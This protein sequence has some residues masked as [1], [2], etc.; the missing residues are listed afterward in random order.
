MQSLS[1][2]LSLSNKT[3]LVSTSS[4]GQLSSSQGQILIWPLGPTKGNPLKVLIGPAGPRVP[5]DENGGRKGGG[6]ED[7]NRERGGCASFS[8]HFCKL[9]PY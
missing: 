2:S 1:L 6:G 3:E 9:S 4:S 5:R 7:K 8:G